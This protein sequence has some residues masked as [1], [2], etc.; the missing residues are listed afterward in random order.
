MCKQ[1]Q[2]GFTIIE[3]LVSISIIGLLLALIIPAVQAARESAQRAQ[4]QSRLKQFGT[5]LH[6]FESINHT[7][8]PAQRAT[9]VTPN[10]MSIHFYAPHVY[11]LPYFDQMTIASK[12]DLQKEQTYFWNPD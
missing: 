11:L 1:T 9:Q 3:L 2:R 4:C 7:F 12:I 5:A 6:A 10:L 8:P